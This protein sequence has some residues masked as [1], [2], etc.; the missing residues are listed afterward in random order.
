VNFYN[1]A[2]PGVARARPEEPV[3][4][5][6]TPVRGRLRR[7]RRRQLPRGQRL[8]LRLLGYEREEL[9]ALRILDI[10]VNESAAA[11]FEAMQRTG[12]RAGRR[13]SGARTA[14][15]SR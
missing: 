14:R 1:C 3:G 12:T 13:G 9:L 6:S 4:E 15:S 2:V 8:T 10:A 11:D 5:R 7:R